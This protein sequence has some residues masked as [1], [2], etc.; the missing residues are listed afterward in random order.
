[1]AAESRLADVVSLDLTRRRKAGRV[2]GP[3][4][5]VAHWPCREI[6]CGK[7]VGVTQSAL[8]AAAMFDV[9]LRRRH[10]KPIDRERTM[11][12]P[13]CAVAWHKRESERRRF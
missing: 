8:D 3:E 9:E 13:E 7:P 11:L 6:A 5:V 10:D 4:P 1:M 2:V 12:C